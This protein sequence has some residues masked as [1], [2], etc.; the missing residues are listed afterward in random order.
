MNRIGTLLGS[1]LISIASNAFADDRSHEGTITANPESIA[2]WVDE[3]AWVGDA[4]GFI[5]NPQTR[6]NL[7]KHNR[8]P[9]W[10]DG[11]DFINDHTVVNPAFQGTQVEEEF[12]RAI[13]DLGTITD[14]LFNAG[15]SH[16]LLNGSFN[17]SAPDGDAPG[18]LDM[19][20][21]KEE[22]SK[23]IG[24][25]MAGNDQAYTSYTRLNPP[26]LDMHRVTTHEAAHALDANLSPDGYVLE[27][28]KADYA[29]ISAETK[30]NLPIVFKNNIYALHVSSERNVEGSIIL[31]LMQQLYM[32]IENSEEL[33]PL[34]PATR[35][36]MNTIGILERD[37][38]EYYTSLTG[39]R[40]IWEPIMGDMR[41]LGT[42]DDIRLAIESR[43]INGQTQDVALIIAQNPDGGDTIEIT[44]HA[45]FKELFKTGDIY[46][47][48]LRSETFAD[49]FATAHD[50]CERS[51]MCYYFPQTTAEVLGLIEAFEILGA[52]A[53]AA[54]PIDP[55]P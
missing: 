8:G 55:A 13:D 32:D 42:R 41:N 5:K 10:S 12:D 44:M 48:G 16:M 47:K 19:F 43:E 7:L 29:Q 15:T 22:L 24:L 40:R 30:D 6:E 39:H 1:G 31:A 51:E 45:G 27:A 18:S 3:L 37:R 21:N 28:L 46:N 33:R 52:Q 54:R 34:F 4:Y 50:G 9:E 23:F 53:Q 2:F 38:Y 20:F 17:E 49:I 35:N 25:Y 36:A 11:H 26:Q 14:F